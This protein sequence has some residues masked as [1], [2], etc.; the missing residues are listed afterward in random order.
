M[1]DKP[2]ALRGFAAMSP[3]RQLEI[4]KKAGASVPADKRSFY[5]NRALATE[6]GRKGGMASRGG[7]RPVVREE[8]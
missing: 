3:E 6:A 7:G 4:A 2:K 1:N 8:G 5:R